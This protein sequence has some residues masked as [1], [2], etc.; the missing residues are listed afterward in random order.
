MPWS[1]LFDWRANVSRWGSWGEAFFFVRPAAAGAVFPPS[2]ARTAE[3]DG[4]RDRH[5]PH[6]VVCA[7]DETQS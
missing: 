2:I 7:H 4:R 3:L 6:T 1:V 5:R